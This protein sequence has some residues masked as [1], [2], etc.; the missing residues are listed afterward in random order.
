MK[1]GAEAST[2]RTNKSSKGNNSEPVRESETVELAS[3]VDFQQD[4]AIEYETVKLN[5][6]PFRGKVYVR[7]AKQVS[8]LELSRLKDAIRNKV[9]LGK[10][11][12]KFA[13]EWRGSNNYYSYKG[14]TAGLTVSQFKNKDKSD[15]VAFIRPSQSDFE[16]YSGLEGQL[17]DIM[18][19][20]CKAKNYN[21][22]VNSLTK[23]VADL[24]DRQIKAR[25][26]EGTK[27]GRFDTQLYLDGQ[28]CQV[29]DLLIKRGDDA[30][31]YDV[32]VTVKFNDPYIMQGYK[33]SGM[34]LN[35][36]LS[37]NNMRIDFTTKDIVKQVEEE[38]EDI[39]FAYE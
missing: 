30:P 35:A 2:E 39:E 8:V 25:I 19:E 21:F 38:D 16:V 22:S 9:A 17:R 10:A 11:K 23:G 1:R 20:L 31:R 34:D 14:E 4:E 26:S 33:D 18:A 15:V 24:P 28:R 29:S 12:D 36:G 13:V 37:A 7:P 6:G 3:E 32:K 5:S 27:N